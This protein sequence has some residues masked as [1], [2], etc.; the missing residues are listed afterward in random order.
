MNQ[1]PV[2]YLNKHKARKGGMALPPEHTLHPSTQIPGI[3]LPIS[4]QFEV[5][6]P[7]PYEPPRPI[8]VGRGGA[9]PLAPH[10]S[11]INRPN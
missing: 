10:S 9:V 6:F 3:T 5:C 1:K 2:S 7:D 11:S 8:K 4:L